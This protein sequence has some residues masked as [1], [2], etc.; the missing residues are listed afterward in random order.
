MKT[1]SYLIM[2]LTPLALLIALGTGMGMRSLGIWAFQLH[3]IAGLFAVILGISMTVL[4]W[5][6]TC[7]W[8]VKEKGEPGTGLGR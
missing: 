6:A 5:S 7:T 2:I 3:K 8:G 1:I 4:W